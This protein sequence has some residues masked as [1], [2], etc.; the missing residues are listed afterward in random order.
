MTGERRIVLIVDDVSACATTLEIAFMRIGN[1][2]VRVARSVDEARTAIGRDRVCALVTDLHLRAATGLDLIRWVRA[3]Q[4]S[5]DMPIIV[6][7][8]DSDPATPA[9]ALRLGANAY[10]GKPFS[11][12]EVRRKL[13]ELIDGD[14][15]PG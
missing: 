3:R 5:M 2:E 10:F 11:P 8:G 15:S 13:E 14:K 7:S 6:V 1:L 4:A 12:S 9:L